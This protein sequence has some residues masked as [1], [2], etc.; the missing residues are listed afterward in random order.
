MGSS[1][2][3]EEDEAPGLEDDEGKSKSEDEAGR[4]GR[5]EAFGMGLY[6]FLTK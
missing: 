5:D 3:M 6:W 4:Y 1:R 2:V